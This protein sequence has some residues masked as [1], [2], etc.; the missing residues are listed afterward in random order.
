[1]K[2]TV[3]NVIID[4]DMVTKIGKQVW[5]WEVPVLEAKFGDGKVRLLDEAEIEVQSKPD[6][7]EEMARMNRAHGKDT[8]D[9]GTNMTY[10]ELAYGRGKAAINALAKEIKRKPRKAKAAA[11]PDPEPE[12]DG[13]GNDPLDL[14]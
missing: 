13:D 3:A 1:M 4:M 14:G 6:P 5:A 9:G 7:A 10:C 8:G 2:A 11:K 12:G